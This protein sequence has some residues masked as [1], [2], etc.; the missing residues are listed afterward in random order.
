MTI[1][2]IC[3]R[4]V[5]TAETGETALDA[6]LRMKRE[7][8][9]TL[10]VLDLARRPIGILTD[11]DLV[12]R[13]MTEGRAPQ[14]IKVVDV[15]THDPRTVAEDASIRDVL[16][17]MRALGVRRMPV[18]GKRGELVGVVSIDDVIELLAGELANLGR[19]LA[20]AAPGTAAPSV[21]V[22]PRG[23]RKAGGIAR[24]AGDLEC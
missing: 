5:H 19:T 3:S 16:A 7:N 23:A 14:S 20:K 4:I 9:G 15:M 21:P 8:V 13:L 10:L 17:A 1:G 2:S 6:A 22:R 24:Q 18:T 11:R 12:V